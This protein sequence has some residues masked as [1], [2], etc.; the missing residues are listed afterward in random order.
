MKITV[1]QEKVVYQGKTYEDCVWGQYQFPSAYKTENGDFVVGVQAYA[2][3]I[4]THGCSDFVWSVSKDGEKWERTDAAI[5]NDFEGLLLP[6][7]DRITYG[8]TVPPA[9]IPVNELKPSQYATAFIPSDKSEKCEDGS[10]PYPIFSFVDVFK[11]ERRIYDVDTLPDGIVKKEWT[12]SRKKKGESEYKVEQVPLEYDNMSVWGTVS[13]GNMVV[14]RPAPYGGLKLDKEGNLWGTTYIGPHI[15][16]YTRGVDMF[17]AVVLFKSTDNAHS[18]K[19]TGYIPFKPD[20]FKHPTSY[21]GV[22]FNEVDIEFMDDGSIIAFLRTTDVSLGGHE[23]NT[24]YFARSTDGGK[25][26]SEPEEFDSLGV[27]PRLLKLDCGATI[28][29]YGRPGIYVRATDDATA[30]VWSEK[31]EIMTPDDRSHLM[32]N[33]PERPNFH[34]WAGSCC[35]TSM[36]PIDEN[37]ALLVYTDF[38]YPDIT[39]KTDKKFKTILSRIITVEMN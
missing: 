22:G 27:F 5:K 29:S 21:L 32:N 4:E 7:G 6:N 36:V 9:T 34:Q 2:D 1:S 11:N 13:N 38:Y 19:L 35:Y 24:M 30:N 14:P 18:F 17:G 15:N 31:L 12:I 10:W 28:L 25:T 26:F 39:G 23:W 8:F 3:L 37:R 33:P 16:P 20:T